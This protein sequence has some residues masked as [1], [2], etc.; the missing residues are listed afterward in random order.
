M[1]IIYDMDGQ[2][3]ESAWVVFRI[4]AQL[5][6]NIPIDVYML[7]DASE[8]RILSF[9]CVETYLSKHEAHTLI[10]DAYLKVKQ[11]L[12]KVV[13][14]AQN[15]PAHDFILK[16]CEEHNLKFK[17]VPA[18]VMVPLIQKTREMFYRDN[19]ASASVQPEPG[20][21]SDPDEKESAR[22][23]IPDSYDT[24]LCNS[25]KMYKFCCKRIAVEIVEAMCA[26]EQ[27]R[28]D[29][30]LSWLAK[31]EEIVGETAETACRKAVILS[32]IDEQKSDEALDRC[33]LLNPKHP[34]AYYLRGLMHRQRNELQ[35]AIEFYKKAIELY[36][37]TAHYYLNEV[38]TNLG[39]V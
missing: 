13:L 28:T 26:A 11:H 7:L 20:H 10:Q 27:G 14:I 35:K 37:E 32:F 34:R 15:D 1:S 12:P 17:T 4:D 16:A 22:A 23:M 30:A 9:I 25:G 3:T 6:G 2:E 33:L 18:L 24:C 19:F 29:L 39:S 31:A 38:Y 8:D 21:C 36:S 5:K